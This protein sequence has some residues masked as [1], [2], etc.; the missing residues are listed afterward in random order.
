MGFSGGL[1]CVWV[2]HFMLFIS[3]AYNL[4][5]RVAVHYRV[6]WNSLKGGRYARARHLSLLCMVCAFNNTFSPLLCHSMFTHG[7]M[8]KLIR[9]ES[10]RFRQ[11][12]IF[13]SEDYWPDVMRS[14]WAACAVC[15]KIKYGVTSGRGRAGF[16]R[17]GREW[18][19]D[20]AASD[21]KIICADLLS[22]WS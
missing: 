9:G 14:E 12:R 1:F 13:S 10:F 16:N 3:S 18:D 22:L 11:S 15:M 6:G 5:Y 21:Y 2:L 4:V 20:V 19:W 8:I 7:L 17:I